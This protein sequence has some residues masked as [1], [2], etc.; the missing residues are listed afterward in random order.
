MPTFMQIHTYKGL[1]ERGCEHGCEAHMGS[2]PCRTGGSNVSE[3]MGKK[4]MIMAAV[5][6]AC[7]NAVPIFHRNATAWCIRCHLVETSIISLCS[8]QSNRMAVTYLCA[9]PALAN[10]NCTVLKGGGMHT[11][12]Y[13]IS[14]SLS[15]RWRASND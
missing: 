13:T 10:V 15:R 11:Y 12:P 6:A 2:L 14:L 8:L 5:H 1:V 3:L 9:L 4:N 7:L